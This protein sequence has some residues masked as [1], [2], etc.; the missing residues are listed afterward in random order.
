MNPM[1]RS[2]RALLLTPPSSSARPTRTRRLTAARAAAAAALALGA[3][4]SSRTTASA[5]SIWI[6]TDSGLNGSGTIQAID[7][8]AEDRLWYAT[9]NGKLA[10]R[11]NG[12]FKFGSGPSAGIVF[13]D[14]AFKP[15]TGIGLAVGNLDQ[16][17]RTADGGKSW[18]RLDPRTVAKRNDSCSDTST[19][20]P[21]AEPGDMYSVAWAPR[22]DVVYMSGDK[23][24][25]LRSADNG[26]TFTEVNKQTA[27][28]CRVSATINDIAVVK[29]P[30]DRSSELLYLQERKAFGR[31]YASLD[32][33]QSTARRR[34]ELTNSTGPDQ[35]FAWDPVY[36]NRIW[37][38]SHEGFTGW[39][40][41]EDGGSSI[42]PIY[43]IENRS[44]IVQEDMYD[45]AYANGTVIL[46]G[47]DGQIVTS[48]MNGAWFYRY[49]D[50]T[51]ATKDWRAV[52]S[53]DGKH[54][55]V[56]GANGTLVLTDKADTFPSA[57]EVLPARKVLPFDL[58]SLSVRPETKR[59]AKSLGTLVGVVL[60]PGVP[61][62]TSAR[63]SCVQGCGRS[64]RVLLRITT[65]KRNAES[66]LTFARPLVVTRRNQIEVRITKTGYVGSLHRIG[67]A[68][69][70]KAVVN[71]L[72][73]S[74]CLTPRANASTPC[75]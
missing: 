31:L 65:A 74:R 15:G 20:T 10:Y 1:R 14:I 50:R 7:Y 33:L 61:S 22:G 44:G 56:G 4:G 6:P 55:A 64:R 54:A 68:R 49:A 60:P 46:A 35:K 30:G 47:N 34:A 69:R 5:A 57:R 23:F 71:T 36:V 13:N 73:V 67:F 12:V 19:G 18:A 52:D 62:G 63:V 37:S 11:E 29:N 24:T 42:E 26:A 75:R 43:K 9:S 16:I 8:Q 41:S 48:R 17:W 45:L 21:G 40:F 3:I 38:I 66:L 72:I 25:I 51:N 59:G 70:R 58:P 32:G 39:S 53:Y 27:G 2:A 28:G